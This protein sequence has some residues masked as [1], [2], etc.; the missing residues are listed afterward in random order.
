MFL[1]YYSTYF[2]FELEFYKKGVAQSSNCAFLASQILHS[3]QSYS[4]AK[5]VVAAFA[6]FEFDQTVETCS[7]RRL[8]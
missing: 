1:Q 3:T 2:S 8:R 7:N 6:F 4:P 5:T